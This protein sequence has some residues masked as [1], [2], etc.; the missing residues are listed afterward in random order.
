MK[1][2][3]FLYVHNSDLNIGIRLEDMITNF[4]TISSANFTETNQLVEVVRN[5]IGREI[6]V[7][8]LRETEE[9]TEDEEN[10]SHQYK[11]K[12]YSLIEIKITP[13]QWEGE[14]VLG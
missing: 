12:H 2:V 8:L 1:E 11:G 10:S 6:P 4:G 5:N 14:G 3:G 13:K 7:K 9:K